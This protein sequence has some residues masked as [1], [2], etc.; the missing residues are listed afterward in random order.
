MGIHI[1]HIQYAPSQEQIASFR[2]ITQTYSMNSS[3]FKKI[4]TNA[5]KVLSYYL[6]YKN[7]SVPFS[8]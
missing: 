7:G 6:I 4:T 2:E 3:K 5:N 1:S 8:T